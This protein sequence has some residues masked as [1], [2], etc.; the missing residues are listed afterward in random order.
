[1]QELLAESKRLY[2]RHEELL[3]RYE[4]LKREM[5]GTRIQQKAPH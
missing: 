4:E 1:M 3:Q 5:A 2:E